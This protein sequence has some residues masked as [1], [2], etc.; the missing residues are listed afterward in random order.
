LDTRIN[1]KDFIVLLVLAI[2]ATTVSAFICSVLRLAHLPLVL[3]SESAFCICFLL[4]YR[5][6]GRSRRWPTLT[7]RFSPVSATAILAAV[8]CAACVVGMHYL[9]FRL[10]TPHG[11]P[12]SSAP[13]QFSR[14]DGQLLA[15]VPVAVLLA[16]F[17]EELIF[18]GMLIDWLKR[19][20][21][22]WAAG[23]VSSLLFAIAHASYFHGGVL[24]VVRFTDTL[25]L[26]V[27]ASIFAIR[28]GSLRP[29][30]VVHATYNLLVA[31][32]ILQS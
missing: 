29:S 3:I 19:W 12:R 22:K 4:G 16:P 5:R 27:G 23:G 30:F 21:S 15:V 14:A 28:C 6:M 26:G 32:L 7:D 2:L 25:M 1:A 13:S 9:L 17:V 18:R 24:A 8:V 20:M 11:I 31:A 10:L